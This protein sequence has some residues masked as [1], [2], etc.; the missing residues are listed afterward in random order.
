MAAVALIFTA[1]DIND[2]KDLN[3]E[4]EIDMSDF[5]LYTEEG[6]DIASKQA[7]DKE[8]INGICYT[9]PNLNRLLNENPGLEKRMYDIEYNT[10]K[11]ILANNL[12]PGN[13]NGG[14]KGSGGNDGSDGSG[15]S[16]TNEIIPYTNFTG[17]TIPVI[18][19]IIYNSSSE[20]IPD[21]QINDQITALKDDF[22]SNN[23]ERQNIPSDFQNLEA[24]IGVNFA[25]AGVIRVQNKKRSWRPD[26]SMKFASSG[27]SDVIDP[28]HY[29]NIWVVNN[30]PYMGGNIL[31]YAQ[32]PGGSWST[33][34]IVLDHRFVGNTSYSTGR[35]ATHEIGHWMNLRHIWG[36]GPCGYDDM[37]TDTPEAD[38]YNTGCH[39]YP[40]PFSC[41]S[42]DMFMN[43]MDYTDDTCM[44]LFTTGQ[45]ARMAAIFNVNNSFRNAMGITIN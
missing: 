5:Y 8:T 19:H 1:C 43:F 24:N 21:S 20:N 22:N 29:L 10:R 28:E 23:P 7:A 13:G 35:T 14:G 4:Q 11:F 40:G 44:N 38:S 15:G 45:K 16:V 17:N 3:Q 12:K 18:F 6:D 9:M 42:N 26:D 39:E 36:D 41:N 2:S 34:G 37:V 25:L 30:M 32:F 31:G 33:D 27:G